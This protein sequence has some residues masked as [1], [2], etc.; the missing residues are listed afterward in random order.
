MIRCVKCVMPDTAQGISFNSEGV[1][2]LC[3]DFKSH[4]ILGVEVLRKEIE[5]HISS[6][7]RYDC[8]VPISGGRD[9]AYALYFAKVELGLNP[10]AVHNDND[11]E[12]EQAKRNLKS[13]VSSLKVDYIPMSSSTN[14]SKKIVREKM[15]MN[16]PFGIDLVVSQTCEACEYGFESAAHNIAKREGVKLILWG[17]SQDESTQSYHS[18]IAQ[19]MPDK[20]SKLFSP[21][22][23]NR[24]KYHYFFRQ[25]QAEYGQKHYPDLVPL[26][27]FDYIRWDRRTIISTIQ[28]KL[29]WMK[30]EGSAT[31]W[32]TDCKLVPLVSYLY[33][34]CYGVSKM[35]LGFSNM[36]RDNK[37]TRDKAL[38]ELELMEKDFDIQKLETLLRDIGVK[39]QTMQ[40]IL[41]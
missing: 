12:T 25:L 9:S 4:P 39:K 23:I 30:P 5:K 13:I 19:K 26:H 20:I 37:M 38:E 27:L 1:C 32:R 18:L 33:H 7:S 10:L 31:T 15:E 3:Q 16:A 29:G 22:V 36:I 17:D 14:L 41:Y 2:N 6:N 8:V 24:L 21:G 11:F 34:K 28:D 35:E 40:T